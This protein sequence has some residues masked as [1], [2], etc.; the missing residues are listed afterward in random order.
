VHRCAL[1]E[2]PRR[3]IPDRVGNEPPLDSQQLAKLVESFG[4]QPGCK[5]DEEQP[6]VLKEAAQIAGTLQTNLRGGL[7]VEGTPTG[8]RKEPDRKI[9]TVVLMPC[10]FGRQVCR[11]ATASRMSA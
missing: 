7:G 6:G 3:D 5:E 1:G 10:L 11:L 2:R 8:S 4:E 9:F